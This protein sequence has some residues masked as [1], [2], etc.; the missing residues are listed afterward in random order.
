MTDSSG[1]SRGSWSQGPWGNAIPTVD[2][3]VSATGGVGSV[4][5]VAEAAV[6]I[7]GVSSTAAVGSTPA[8]GTA[9]VN[10]VGVS[11]TALV[12]SIRQ[13]GLATFEGWGRSSWGQGP[14]GQPVT[15]PTGAVG[16]VGSVTTQVNQRAFVES[17]ALVASGGTVSAFAGTGTIVTL[18]GLSAAT[19]T[20]EDG[21]LV[22][23]RIVPS[24]GN[25]WSPIAP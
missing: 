20:N 15:L 21:V 7:V 8:V 1:W 13:D 10:L 6:T 23:G 5:V 2:S 18:V 12:T 24:A 11:A 19:A 3:G 4:S 9:L 25:I 17:V 14:W 16:E 22:W